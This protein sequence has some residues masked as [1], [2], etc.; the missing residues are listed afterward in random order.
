MRI[1]CIICKERIDKQD[2]YF[3]VELFKNK[4]SVGIDYAHQICWVRRNNMNSDIKK[5]TNSAINILKS[6][7]LNN[8][9]EQ[10][11]VIQ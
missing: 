8:P 1:K 10:V 11:V 6:D 3:K 9:R 4:E 5:L 7:E 2:N